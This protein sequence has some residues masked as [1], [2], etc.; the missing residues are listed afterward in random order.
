MASN[1]WRDS[2]SWQR[3]YWGDRV[4][5]PQWRAVVKAAINGGEYMTR[6]QRKPAE[7]PSFKVSQ[8]ADELKSAKTKAYQEAYPGAILADSGLPLF[9]PIRDDKGNPLE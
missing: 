9:R 3:A 6:G 8:E 1:D 2:D 4:D 7:V 5:D